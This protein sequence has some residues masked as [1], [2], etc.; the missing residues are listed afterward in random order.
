M[1]KAEEKTEG[2]GRG[3]AAGEARIRKARMADVEPIH[4]MIT[5]WSRLQRMLPR[6]RAE[7]YESLRD[8]QVAE[9]DGR[10]VG[11]AALVIAWENLAEIRSLGVAADY[12]GRGIGRRLVEACLAEA[13]RIGVRR[14][15]ALTANVAF[16]QRLAFRSV[17]KE[18]LPHKIWGDCIKCPKFPD[19]DEEAAA[20]D[21]ANPEA[22]NRKAE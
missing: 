11:C 2:E 17:P 12:Q 6:S 1:G 10:V 7:L 13:R 16:F 8:F 18:E 14:V 15:F 3:G 20:I 19:C 21:L 9:A 22:G 5:E 4:R